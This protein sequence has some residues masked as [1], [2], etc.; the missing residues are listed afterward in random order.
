[1]RHFLFVLLLINSLC[2]CVCNAA[3]TT[4]TLESSFDNSR[5][6]LFN[7]VFCVGA[8]PK[9]SNAQCDRFRKFG[10]IY[11]SYLVLLSAIVNELIHKKCQYRSHV[12]GRVA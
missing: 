2:V 11:S 1:M 4:A 3:A 8:R 10:G 9:K 6:P 7:R 12:C 5:P